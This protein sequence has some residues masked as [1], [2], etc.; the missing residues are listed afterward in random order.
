MSD[1]SVFV[2]QSNHFLSK[3]FTKV[4]PPDSGAAKMDRIFSSLLLNELV[5]VAKL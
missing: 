2:L 1:Y 3:T 5:H 4:A